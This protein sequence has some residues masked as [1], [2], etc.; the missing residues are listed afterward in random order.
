MELRYFESSDII[1]FRQF[2]TF[3]G[4]FTGSWGFQ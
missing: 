3:F 4:P 2:W 1:Q